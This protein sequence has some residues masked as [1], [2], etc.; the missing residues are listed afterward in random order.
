MALAKSMVLS[1]AVGVVLGVRDLSEQR[2]CLIRGASSD[3]FGARGVIIAG[4][5]CALRTVGLALG[6]GPPVVPAASVLGGLGG[7]L[8]NPAV[9]ACLAQEAGSARPRRSS[10]STRSPP[11][12]RCLAARGRHERP[13]LRRRRDPPRGPRGAPG[14]NVV[15]MTGDA[16]N[17]YGALPDSYSNLAFFKDLSVD[18]VEGEKSHEDEWGFWGSLR[19]E[20]AGKS[21]ADLIPVDNRAKAMTVDQL[22]ENDLAPTAHRP[23]RADHSLVDGG[24]LRLRRLRADP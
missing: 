4:G 16:E 2:L 13:L 9:R 12:G 15:A 3:R 6:D 20:N 14:L 21:H 17:M 18:F 7:V 10:C 22:A 19:W 23:G 8:F 5:R 24:A 11:P 1:A